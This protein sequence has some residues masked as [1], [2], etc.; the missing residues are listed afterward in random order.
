MKAVLHREHGDL[1]KLELADIPDPEAAEGGVRIRVDSCGLN[2]LDL[3]SLHGI[4]GVK[5]PLPHI[6][7]SDIAGVVDAVGARAGGWSVGDRVV[8]NPSLWCGHCEFCRRGDIN[9]CPRY[10]IIG[11]NVDGG[12]AEFFACPEKHLLKVPDG[13]PSDAA[14][15]AALVYQTAWRM[16]TVR[17]GLRAGQWV[18][19]NGAGG[20]VATA[21]IQIAKLHGAHVV[22]TTSTPE[23]EKRA[24]AIGAD[25]VLNYRTQEVDREVYKITGKRGVDL[26]VDNVG[27]ETWRSNLR[28]LARGGRLAICGGTTGNGPDAMINVLFWKQITVHGSTM[29]NWHDFENVMRLVF[30]GTLKPVIDRVVPITDFREAFARLEAG[31]QFGKIVL[32]P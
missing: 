25:Y 13:F 31:E 29:G 14:A 11:E 12:M 5:I 27:N 1:D 19:V 30:H 20:G 16:V 28:A 24:R 26:V 22:A 10:G 6:P 18:L 15:A 32:K 2:H 8:V 21:A 17:G 4:E 23:K 3:W 7:G 9:Y